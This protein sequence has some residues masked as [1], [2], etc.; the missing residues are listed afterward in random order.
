MQYTN[1]NVMPLPS[2]TAARGARRVSGAMPHDAIIS[3]ECN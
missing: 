3:K 2:R 1:A